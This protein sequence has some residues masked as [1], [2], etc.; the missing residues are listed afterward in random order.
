[1]SAPLPPSEPTAGPQHSHQWEELLGQMSGD[2]AMVNQTLADLRSKVPGYENVPTPSL[3]A[4]V[5]RN[6]DLTIRTIRDGLE[7]APDQVAEADA[8]AGERYAQGVP[9]GSVLAGFRVSLSLI[10][11]NILARAPEA[12]IPTEQILTSSTL[13]WALGDAFSTRAVA[14]YQEK[15]VSRAVTDSALRAEWIRNVVTTSM[16][17]AERIRG[18]TL[19]DVPTNE[20]IRAIV[21]NAPSGAAVDRMQRLESW[22]QKA[23][24]RVLAA[25]QGSCLVGIMV[26]QP[27]ENV[28]ATG[29]TIGLG[30]ATTLDEL[31]RSF[32]SAS[33]AL[34][35][36]EKV[37]RAGLVDLAEL[38]WQ[39]GVHACPETTEILY[40]LHLSPLEN[41]GEFSQHILEA[42]EAYLNHRMSIPLAARSIPVHV[43]T[44]RYRLQ[45]FS[46]LTGADLGDL[47]TL[48][49]LAWV[50][51]SG[52]HRD[53]NSGSGS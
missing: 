22:A 40:R 46:E 27:I 7:P 48:I 30:E 21:L 32:Q 35:A 14:V 43:N 8:L 45:R 18:A 24:T 49:E 12:G 15:E 50:L 9:I 3:E 38:S 1:M 26:E 52:R 29:L 36:A 17:P 10:F 28:H 25:V 31:P 47:N 33:M 11:R 19:H 23:D 20:P 6:I 39:L 4:S 16:P 44:L 41:S 13:L 5:R 53:L 37:G 2:Q 51:A 42:V 34:E